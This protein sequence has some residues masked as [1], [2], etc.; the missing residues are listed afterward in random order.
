MGK[1]LILYLFSIIFFVNLSANDSTFIA[2]KI[3]SIEGEYKN[4]EVDNMGNIYLINSFNQIKKINSK[5]DSVAVFNDTKQFGN[6]TLLDV[7]NPL[8]ILVYYGE[9]NTILILDRFLNVRS[10]IDL[11]K[12]NIFKVSVIALSFDNNIWLFDEVENNFKKLDEF[13]N[14]LMTSSDFR[15]ILN[16]SFVPESIIDN[17]GKLY[18][19]NSKFGLLSFDYYGGLQHNY[20]IKYLNDVQFAN[21]R[22]IGFI[23]DDL[24]DYDFLLMTSNAYHLKNIELGSQKFIFKNGFLYTLNIK[25][26]NIFNIEKLK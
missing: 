17:N 18:L 14:V 10:K 11:R 21:D 25:N 24:I 15:L 9:F 26:L 20:T 1:R 12:L 5:L 8:K 4:F 6:I 3:N 22:F 2:K 7:S 19:Y 13:G 23:N 16:T